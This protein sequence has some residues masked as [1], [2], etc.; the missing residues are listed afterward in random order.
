[1]DALR[2]G[3]SLRALRIRRG[4]RQADVASMAGCSQRQVSRIE[5]GAIDRTSLGT[6]E[7]LALAL[8]AQL[9]VRVRWRGEGLDRLL[10]EAHAALVDETVRRLVKL[11]W[12]C[13]VEV[14]FS[15]FGE[16]GSIDVMGW[17]PAA[18]SLLVIEVKSLVPDAQA[19]I[20]SLD[21]KARL[22]ATVAKS[23]G[24]SAAHVG[25]L[26]VI[27]DST[28]SR[29][30]VTRFDA[31][32]ATAYP[33]RRSAVFAWLRRPVGSLSGLIF[34]PDSRGGG[35][36]RPAAGLQRVQGPRPPRERTA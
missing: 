25:R 22:A 32:F 1:M 36:R 29:R 4:W 15:V 18:L 16:R 17:H 35:A 24:W 26:L 20:S 5:L 9:D 28:T 21:R 33:H 23:R 6:L 10:D 11:G 2:I 14:S 30:R 3:R 19:M 31:L 8:G 13:E 34:L 7:A 12:M 27:G